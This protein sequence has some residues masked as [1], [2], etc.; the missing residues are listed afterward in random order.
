MNIAICGDSWLT[1]DVRVPGAHF[2]EILSKTHNV[3]N[4]ARGGMSNVGICFQIQSALRTC[5]DVLIM[6]TTD[7]NRITF[8]IDDF[9]EEN[10]IGNIRYDDSVSATCDTPHVGSRTAPIIDD[11]LLTIAEDADWTILNK[12]QKYSLPSEIK[13]AVRQYATYLHN[14]KFKTITDSWITHY[15]TILAEQ[16]QVKVI[17]FWDIVQAYCSKH[18]II[19]HSEE[20]KDKWVFHTKLNVQI[21]L[22]ELVASAIITTEQ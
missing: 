1:P 21:E 6:N 5:P 9:N 12:K 22:A 13:L 4:Y 14:E 8:P 11:V 17:N 2:T 18:N 16:Q 19:I 3:T 15:W 10:G 7:S 20:L